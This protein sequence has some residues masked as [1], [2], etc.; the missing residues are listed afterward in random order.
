MEHIPFS[1]LRVL[2]H[3]PHNIT[4]FVQ[5]AMIWSH[6]PFYPCLKRFVQD[7]TQVGDRILVVSGEHAGII[8]HI[9]TIQD[10]VVE[11]V[12]QSPEQHSGLVICLT[13]RDLIPHFFPGDN[14]KDRWSESFGMVV[15]INHDE[16]KVTF[17]DRE[18]NA[19]V[20]LPPFSPFPD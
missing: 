9:E 12:T 3:S 13:L 10:N 4:S 6:P 1:Y 7:S 15:T 14:V 11:V 8:G 19:E 2:E 18:A 17:L 5:S 20:C 16:Q